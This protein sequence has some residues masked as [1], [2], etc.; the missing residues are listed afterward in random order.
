MPRLRLKAKLEHELT[1]LARQREF[2]AFV[3]RFILHDDILDDDSDDDGS[4]DDLNE[5]IDLQVKE[6][7]AFVSNNRYIFRSKQYRNRHG[8]FDWDDCLS[9][10]SRRYNDTEFLKHFRVSRTNFWRLVS[11][12]QNH[13]EF[14]SKKGKRKRSTVACHCLVYLY[15]LGREGADGSTMSIAS[16]FGIGNGTVLNYLARVTVAIKSL[17]ENII[18]WPDDDEKEDIK[19]RIRVRY[20]FQNCIGIIDG[21]LIGL[22]QK[23]SVYGE[24]Y[25][26]RKQIYAINVQVICDD[27]RRIRYFYGGWPGSTHDNR[28]WRNSKVFLDAATYFHTGEYLLGDSAYSTSSILVPS[29]KSLP[30]QALGPHKEFFNKGH[31]AP[32]VVSEHCIGILKNRFPCLKNINI[33]V[34]GRQGLKKIMDLLTCCCILHNIFIDCD[35]DIPKEW[36]ENIDANHYWTSDEDDSTV[37]NG[38]IEM[39]DRRDAVYRA[40]I[41]DYYC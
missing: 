20:G 36:Y 13:E 29:F 35:D 30:G 27:Q 9:D 6:A 38:T 3:R 24:S 12:I 41:S 21:T 37:M 32:R 14:K 17:K 40:Y 5:I 10:S 8:F 28:A 23:P 18:T 11:L 39:F 25:F 2:D 31:A 22:F 19:R 33:D 26:C 7:L 34:N 4:D 15:R 1:K 16:Y